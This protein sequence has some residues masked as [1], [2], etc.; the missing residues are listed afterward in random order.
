MGLIERKVKEESKINGTFI[1]ILIFVIA[2]SLAIA[3]IAYI[4][5][6]KNSEFRVHGVIGKSVTCSF[7]EQ[8]KNYTV[9][10]YICSN[11]AIVDNS[12]DCLLFITTSRRPVETTATTSTVEK[13]SVKRCISN[14]C[15][16]IEISKEFDFLN[17]ECIIDKDCYDSLCYKRTTTTTSTIT[18]TTFTTTT[19][20]TT[21]TTYQDEC[22]I[23]GCPKGTKYVGSK[24]TGYYYRCASECG[25][26]ITDENRVCIMSEEEAKQY[27]FVPCPIRNLF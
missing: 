18:K 9:I 22:T 6:K 1:L 24:K 16:E 21:T 14:R 17:N 3:Y 20:K 12:T 27:G 11:G 23:L 4:T 10:R 13:F 26:K 2:L 8:C 19:K 25:A 5:I 15:I 7:S